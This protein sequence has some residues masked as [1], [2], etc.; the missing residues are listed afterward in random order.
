MQILLQIL[1]ISI[2]WPHFTTGP[3]DGPPYRLIVE[4]AT[5]WPHFVIGPPNDPLYR[6][7]VEIAIFW[8][9]LLVKSAVFALFCHSATKWSIIYAVFGPNFSN[10][11]H[12]KLPIC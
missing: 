10:G 12:T 6:L 7:I 1:E 11:T 3:P 2:F 8:P 5:F 4:M 9:H